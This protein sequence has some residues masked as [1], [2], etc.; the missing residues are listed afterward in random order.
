[1]RPHNEDLSGIFCSYAR[2]AVERLHCPLQHCT[3]V[4]SFG[5][6]VSSSS[7]PFLM[8]IVRGDG[9]VASQLIELS[10]CVGQVAFLNKSI[11]LCPTFSKHARRLRS[12]HYFCDLVARVVNRLYCSV[13]PS[14]PPDPTIR[15]SSRNR[16]KPVRQWLGEKP[17]YAVSPG[18]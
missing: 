11:L 8:G 18:G 5:E 13:H 4:N 14:P 9:T 7:T 12:G 10:F 6:T 1:M 2:F 16:M 17:V 15:R 3:A